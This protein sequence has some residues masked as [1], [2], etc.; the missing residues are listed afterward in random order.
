MG[1]YTLEKGC[2]HLYLK[3]LN[4]PRVFVYAWEVVVKELPTEI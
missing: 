4:E 3:I 2:E 1:N